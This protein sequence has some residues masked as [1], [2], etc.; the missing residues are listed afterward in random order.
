MIITIEF[1]EIF[2]AG[3]PDKEHNKGFPEC[4]IKIYPTSIAYEKGFIL[5][6]E[7]K[8]KEVTLQLLTHC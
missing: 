1:E 4:D 5:E 8:N 6:L 7:I 2:Q 3:V